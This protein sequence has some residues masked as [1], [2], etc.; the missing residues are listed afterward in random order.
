MVFS[1]LSRELGK[2]HVGHRTLSGDNNILAN[3]ITNEITNKVADI[4][5]NNIA[6]EIANVLT[7]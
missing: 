3:N 2:T 1:F 7:I 4:L 5:A 6:N